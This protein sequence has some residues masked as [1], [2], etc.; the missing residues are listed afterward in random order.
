MDW[1]RRRRPDR[2]TVWLLGSVFAYGAL[3]ATIRPDPYLNL[4]GMYGRQALLFVPLFVGLAALAALALRPQ[5]PARYLTHTMLPR[6]PALAATILAFIVGM[7]GFTVFKLA[8]PDIVPFYADPFLAVIEQ[9]LFAGQHPGM[10]L[11]DLLPEQLAPV[12]GTLYGPVWVAL[13][14]GVLVMAALTL[15]RA[16]ARRFFWAMILTMV[17]L[18]TVVATLASSVGPI[19]YDR[20]YSV[21]L[22][23][24]LSHRVADGAIGVYVEGAADYLLH[25]YGNHDVQL[26]TG[27][28]AM[29]SIHVAIATLAA[30]FAGALLP[31]LRWC[32]W[33]YVGLI[34]LGSVYT[35]W[36]YAAD[37]LVSLLLVPMLWRLA[38]RLKN[39]FSKTQRP[40]EATVV[41]GAMVGA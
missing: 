41:D 38:G 25:A 14:F 22:F 23:A 32:G 36:H 1:L 39:V 33:V 30:L 3:A 20:F 2:N 4:L 24:D 19:F 11:H 35:G 27:I 28:S 5:A 10:L 15:D 40:P 18:G 9:A 7:A 16:L 34:M 8:I 29:P 6:L 12:I 13:W 31:R 17:V 26:G 37:G 21:D